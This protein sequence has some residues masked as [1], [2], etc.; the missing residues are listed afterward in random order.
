VVRRQPQ[1]RPLHQHL[2]EGELAQRVLGRS[3]E[4][5]HGAREL[6]L[7]VR[8]GGEPRRGGVGAPRLRHPSGTPQAVGAS[9]EEVEL[10]PVAYLVQVDAL[11]DPLPRGGARR[12]RG[13]RR[14][15]RPAG[16]HDR[17]DLACQQ[18][19]VEPS[20]RR[21][22]FEP[23]LRAPPLPRIAVGRERVGGPSRERLGLHE[24]LGDPLAERMELR[25]LLELR[26][27][28]SGVAELEVEGDPFLVGLQVQN[29]EPSDGG[30]GE[31]L[32][33]EPGQGLA[34]PQRQACR[35]L[36]ARLR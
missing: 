3:D 35:Q 7:P 1:H 10:Q 32:V 30:L 18:P 36:V 26:Q 13:G 33:A 6:F 5:Q 15:R 28:G 16:A 14:D 9:E 4:S 25:Q 23:E 12:R 29:L 21:R 11:D 20:E 17:T 19:L 22:R 27:D 31:R 34:P 24:Q 2:V 8:R